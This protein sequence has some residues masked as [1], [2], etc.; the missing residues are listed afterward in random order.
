MMMTNMI[1]LII[2][3]LATA[4]LGAPARPPEEI[5]A[6]E[7]LQFREGGYLVAKPEFVGIEAQAL[8]KYDEKRD[9]NGHYTK[10]SYED[11]AVIDTISTAE[12]VYGA[13]KDHY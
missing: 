1:K 11:F 3:T 10:R 9:V 7:A 6:I 12:Q 2:L 5:D 8:S 13:I 4:A